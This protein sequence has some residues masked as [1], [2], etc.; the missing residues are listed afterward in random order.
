MRG[1]I[2]L[3]PE[4]AVKVWCSVKKTHR[5]NFAFTFTCHVANYKSYLRLIIWLY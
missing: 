5:D 1:A 2:P 3:L 4:Y